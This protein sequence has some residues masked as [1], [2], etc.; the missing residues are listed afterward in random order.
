MNGEVLVNGTGPTEEQRTARRVIRK[1][2]GTSIGKFPTQIAEQSLYPSPAIQP[3]YTEL[4]ILCTGPT[5]L[6]AP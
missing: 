1:F 4:T 3:K 5:W 2:G 6:K